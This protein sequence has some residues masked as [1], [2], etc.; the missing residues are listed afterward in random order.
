MENCR[1]VRSRGARR[2]VR[3]LAIVAIVLALSGCRSPDKANIE[4]RRQNQALREEIL[5]LQRQRAA[6]AASI[7]AL[8]ESRGASAAMALSSEQ[9]NRLFTVAGI[10]CGRLTAFVIDGA[11]RSALR[12]EAVPIDASGQP[13]K[14]AGTFEVQLL[15]APEGGSALQTWS[16]DLEQSHRA[17]NGEALLYT[18]LLNCPLDQVDRTRPLFVQ[19]RFTDELT[20]RLFTTLRPLPAGESS[21]RGG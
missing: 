18:Y 19:V 14:S 8:R 9:L 12:V 5:V 2:G 17:W 21:D 20:G 3:P 4:L 13:L 15:D 10:E 11:G 1:I 7:E 16:F 6:D